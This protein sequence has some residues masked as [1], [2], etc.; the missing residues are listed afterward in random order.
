MGDLHPKFCNFAKK[1]TQEILPIFENLLF[2]NNKQVG[3]E[4]IQTYKTTIKL[5]PQKQN[6]TD[7]N[8]RAQK[9]LVKIF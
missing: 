5:R 2:W 4:M 6:K 9:H 7:Y 3:E 1:A 8:R